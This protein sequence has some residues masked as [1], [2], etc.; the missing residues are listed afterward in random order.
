VGSDL[1]L[2]SMI[3][4]PLFLRQH[5]FNKKT[6]KKK[7]RIKKKVKKGRAQSIFQGKAIGRPVSLA[8]F[9]FIFI[10]CS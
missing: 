5:A 7:K 2:L 6:K 1:S 4:G 10:I 9:A 3:A 8:S